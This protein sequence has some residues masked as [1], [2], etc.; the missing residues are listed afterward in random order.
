MYMIAAWF[1]SLPWR[2]TPLMT[3]IVGMALLFAVFLA[4]LPVMNSLL[5]IGFLGMAYLRG[6]PAG[7]S[8][9]GS[10]P[11]D[12]ALILYIFGHSH[13]SYLWANSVFS[14]GLA[15]TCIVWPIPGWGGLPGGLAMG[16]IVACGGFAAVSGDSMATA[17]TMGTVAIP[18]MKRF[19]YDDGMAIG[20]V[21]AGGTLGVL[22]PP[23]LGLY[24]VCP[25]GGPIHRHF[26]HCGNHPRNRVDLS[27]YVN[28]FH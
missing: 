14:P 6:T 9:M 5:L 17:V 21:A 20:C 12:T 2:L 8:I 10:S 23:S 11:F 16:T 15:R 4:G 28:H 19:H 25:S 1:R 7:M 26:V 18:E 13:F 3:G 27:F 22:I 24:S